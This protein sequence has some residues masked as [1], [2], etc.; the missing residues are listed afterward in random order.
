[1]PFADKALWQHQAV[2]KPNMAQDVSGIAI[3]YPEILNIL[4]RNKGMK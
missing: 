1:M 2:V 4:K 3:I